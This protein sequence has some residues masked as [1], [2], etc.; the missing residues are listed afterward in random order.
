MKSKK[1]QEN[2]KK[3]LK[4]ETVL[5]TINYCKKKGKEREEIKRKKYCKG[6][7]L[8]GHS[9]QFLSFVFYFSFFFFWRKLSA[10][11]AEAVASLTLGRLVSRRSFGNNEKATKK[12]PRTNMIWIV[13]KFISMPGLFSFA[14]FP[15]ISFKGY[16]SKIAPEKKG[17]SQGPHGKAVNYVRLKT[18]SNRQQKF[19]SF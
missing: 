12:I 17:Y 6:W 3:L 7:Q 4:Y 19:F 9:V 8:K 2:E 1:K 18:T 16:V 13:L 15:R 14:G 10:T 5:W 11:S